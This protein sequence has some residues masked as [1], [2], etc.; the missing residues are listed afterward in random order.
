M[1]STEDLIGREVVPGE[2]T[3][4]ELGALIDARSWLDA[5]AVT[6]IDAVFGKL[7]V[8]WSA[9][10]T[11]AAVALPGGRSVLYLAIEEA[12]GAAE[13]A[14]GLHGD[15]EAACAAGAIILDAAV[16]AAA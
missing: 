10:S 5:R 16:V 7:P 8:S 1:R 4:G 3:L 13:V 2:T 12:L 14:S 15:P 6:V 9:G 11:V